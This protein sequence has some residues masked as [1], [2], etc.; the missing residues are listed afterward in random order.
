MEKQETW[1]KDWFNSYYYHLLYNHRNYSEARMF[2]SNLLNHLNLPKENSSVLDLAC[3][4]GRHSIQMNKLGYA[5][6]GMDLSPESINH[7]NKNANDRLSFKTG[8]MRDFMFH[9][10]FDLIVN[11]FTSFGY[12]KTEGDNQKVVK[13]ISKNLKDSGIFVLDYLNVNK[14]IQNFPTEEIIDKGEIIFHIQKRV[15]ENFIVKDI[16]F[17]HE[18]KK[19]HFQEFVKLIDLDLFHIYFENAGLSIVDTFGDYKLNSF[20]SLNSD[21]L[22]LIAEKA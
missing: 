5:V 11:L 8:D 10:Q 12:F 21:R 19:F 13:A 6:T 2:I 17:E 20:D 15:Q 3:G 16:D 4:K 1:F 9:S 14:A 18:N 7:A 22:I